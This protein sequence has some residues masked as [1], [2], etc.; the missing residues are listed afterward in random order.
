MGPGARFE[1]KSERVL[2]AWNDGDEALRAVRAALPL[3]RTAGSADIAIIDPPR[4]ASGRPEPGG[5]LASYLAR[6]GIAAE[7]SI[8][9]RTEPDIA[10][11]LIRRA[12]EIGAGLIVMGAYG[13]T[14]LREAIIGGA[15]RHMLERARLPVLMA[16]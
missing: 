1:P 13:H 4:T 3:L 15:T 5:A 10:D 14:R 11:I 8:L 16:H 6:H 2:I 12:R 9:A 7:V